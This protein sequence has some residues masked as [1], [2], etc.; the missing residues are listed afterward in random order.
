[1]Q[2]RAYEHAQRAPRLTDRPAW[3]SGEDGEFRLWLAMRDAR[4]PEKYIGARPDRVRE[5]AIIE[6]ADDVRARAALGAGLVISGPVGTGKSSAASVVVR[7][8]LKA[9][10]TARYVYVPNL[11]EHMQERINRSEAVKVQLTPDLLVWDDLG[12]G[13]L[14]DWQVGWLDRIV[15]LRY[16]RSRPMVVTTNLTA[17]SLMHTDELRR[18]VD[19][20]RERG[21]L[22][23]I[24]GE[25][26]RSLW[27]KES[28]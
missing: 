11:I 22:V 10:L 20:W 27:K 12:V 2:E 28:T 9:D 7:E 13:G 19:R 23:V 5:R 21:S 26:Q 14:A 1:M 4:V 3:W 17:R 18:M 16:Q 25:S 15:E 8:A 6:Y 24:G